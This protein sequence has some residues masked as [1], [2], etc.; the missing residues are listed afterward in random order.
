MAVGDWDSAANWTAGV[1]NST[2]A[3]VCISGNA[4]VLLTAASFSIG[5]LTVSAGSSLTIG[6]TGST[7]STAST[8]AE[9]DCV[10]GLQNDGSLTVSPRGRPATPG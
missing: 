4:N 10:V 3:D 8:T 6:S 2:G 9:L 7:A 1:P 5:Q